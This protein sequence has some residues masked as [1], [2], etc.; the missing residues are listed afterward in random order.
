MNYIVLDLE[1][2]QGASQDEKDE[3]LPFEI[4]EIGAVKVNAAGE[5]IDQF[6]ELIK[7]SIYHEMHHITE[8]LIHIQ[9][10]DL[11]EGRSFIEVC[12]DFMNWCGEDYTFCTWGTLD[13]VEL[14]RNMEYYEFPPLSDRPLPYLDIQK[15]FAL[16]YEDK[17][18]RRNLEYA[19]DF[20][21]ILKSDP[22]HRAISDAFYTAKVFTHILAKN[23][24]VVKYV[25]YDVYHP[26]VSRDQEVRVIFDTYA[27]YIS[28]VFEDKKEAFA[29][30]EVSS[31]KC[32]YCHKN[33]RKKVKWFTINNK[34]YYCLAYCEKH[35]Y[36]KCKVR[37][38]KSNDGKVFAVK[39][40]RFISEEEKDGLIARKEHA[41]EMRKRRK[42]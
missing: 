5:I 1:W 3:R 12:Q 35:G 32:Y 29:D 28:R 27:K 34:H 39:T 9:M 11:I 4:I 26:P 21:G 10:E 30:K 14:Q 36:A 20:L 23:P 31:S 24:E 25:S 18:T 22:F 41:S 19:T 7:P 40:T 16:T 13:L 6:C 38:M 42:H 17:K 37:L 15:L 33:L 2:N 8:K